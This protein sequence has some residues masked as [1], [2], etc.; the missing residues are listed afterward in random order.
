[1]RTLIT[2][3]MATLATITVLAACSS[4]SSSKDAAN[5]ADPNSKVESQGLQL[6]GSFQG[7]SAVCEGGN[8]A[9]K[10]N[11][12]TLKTI[13]TFNTDATTYKSET[14][15]MS[16]SKSADGTTKEEVLE[17]SGT[18]S[19]TGDVLT[20]IKESQTYEGQVAT[21]NEKSDV[22]FKLDG[23][24]LTVTVPHGEDS[25]CPGTEAMIIKYQRQVPDQA[26]TDTK[27]EQKPETKTVPEID[28]N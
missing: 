7:V 28:K 5:K 10:D 1:M 9:T 26:A 17:T 6:V 22:K 20:L 12:T 4:S 13:L 24:D 8:E 27:P 21:T 3:T 16:T 2:N 23:N 15:I 14:K 18:Y 11:E 19:V 25:S